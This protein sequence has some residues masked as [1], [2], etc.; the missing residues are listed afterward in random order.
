M[1][2][3]IK[4]FLGAYVNFPNA[5]NINCD[6]IAKYLDKNK[7]EV[8]TMYSS[9]KAIDKEYYKN[10]N[11]HLHKLIHHRFIWYWCKWLT[12]RLGNFDI[13][14]LPK[15]ESVDRNFS[16]QF[17]NIKYFIASVEGVITDSV[18]N[19]EQFRSYYMDNMTN[20]FSISNCIE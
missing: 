18:N 10:Q 12:M 11:I 8:H 15:V 13:Y 1:K 7:F 2:K 4:I 6:Y 16:N 20:F 17:K 5:Q 3:K 19:S 9:K 14:Y